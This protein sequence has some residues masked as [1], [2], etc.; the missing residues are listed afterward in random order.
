[1]GG[2]G[3]MK[4]ISV[5]LPEPTY[6]LLQKRA[7]ETGIPPAVLCRAWIRAELSNFRDPLHPEVLDELTDHQVQRSG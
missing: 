1:M 7:Q 5:R 6:Q 2:W 4:T 3:N